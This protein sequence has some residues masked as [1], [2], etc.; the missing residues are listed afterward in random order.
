MYI[1][2]PI[3]SPTIRQQLL[4]SEN[5]LPAG[6]GWETSLSACSIRDES[7]EAIHTECFFAC[8]RIMGLVGKQKTCW[9]IP[10]VGVLKVEVLDVE[11]KPFTSQRDS[12]S[13]RFPPNCVALCRAW[14]SWQSVSQPLLPVSLWL[15]SHLPNVWKWLS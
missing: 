10:Q 13:W 3:Q 6:K 2:C 9:P 11:S 15:F 14:G 7:R 1:S 12:G 8:C 4:K 5:R